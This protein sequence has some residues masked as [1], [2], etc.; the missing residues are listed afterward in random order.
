MSKPSPRAPPLMTSALGIFL[1][2]VFW[3]DHPGRYVYSSFPHHL[4]QGWMLAHQ[5][6]NWPPWLRLSNLV[7]PASGGESRNVMP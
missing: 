3:L 1:D 4:G 7:L 5:L 6:P 2:S